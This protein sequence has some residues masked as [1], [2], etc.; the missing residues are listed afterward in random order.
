MSDRIERTF[1][2]IRALPPEQQ[3]HVADVLEDV[4]LDHTTAPPLSAEEERML[5]AAIVSIDAGRGV[6][7][8]ELDAFWN[9]HQR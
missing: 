1:D 9:R 8:R 7:G 2:K 3:N 6:S 4:V 5:D